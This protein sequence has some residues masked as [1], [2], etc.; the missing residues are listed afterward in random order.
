MATSWASADVLC[1]FYCTDSEKEIKCEGA[2]Y[3]SQIK[4]SFKSNMDKEEAMRAKCKA[5]YESC[6]FYKAIM[7]KYDEKELNITV[8]LPPVTKKNSQQIFK[9]PA[10]G[11]FFIAPSKAYGEYEKRALQYIPT[12]RRMERECSVKCLFYMPTHRRVDLV[13]LLE[14]ADDLLVKAGVLPDD[15]SEIIF[16]HDGSRVKYD[17]DKPRTEITIRYE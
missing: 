13:N 4:N 10:T 17:K 12:D 9:N 2:F 8:P 15:S 16:S 11:A 5:N 14:A 1:P 3:K 7:E 6:P